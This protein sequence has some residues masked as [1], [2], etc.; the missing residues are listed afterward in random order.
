MLQSAQCLL[1][2]HED[3][4]SNPDKL[5]KATVTLVLIRRGVQRQKNPTTLAGHPGKSN[6]ELYVQCKNPSQRNKLEQLRRT[7]GISILWLQTK[8]YI[9]ECNTQTHTN[10]N[11]NII[12]YEFYSK[13]S[14]ILIMCSEICCLDQLGASGKGM[15]AV[16]SCVDG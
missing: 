4:N 8:M 10:K 14:E 11:K 15:W 3:L 16:W 5:L 1:F 13:L 6:S 9:H 2:K 7:L 12:L